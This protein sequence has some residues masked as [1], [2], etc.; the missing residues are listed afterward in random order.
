MLKK[1]LYDEDDMIA[2]KDNVIEDRYLVELTG[3]ESEIQK[4]RMIGQI[5]KQNCDHDYPELCSDELEIDTVV[6]TNWIFVEVCVAK[7]NCK[8]DH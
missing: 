8:R 5:V 1:I 7:S 4:N 2:N 6:G 3:D